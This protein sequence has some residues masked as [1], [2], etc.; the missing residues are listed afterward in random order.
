M[1]ELHINDRY[2]YFSPVAP[3]IGGL[4]NLRSLVLSIECIEEIPESIGKLS[5]LRKLEISY[6]FFLE[7]L[8]DSIGNL[9]A[10]QEILIDNCQALQ[11]LPD[12][13]GDLLALRDISIVKCPALS[14]LP[15]S[16]ISLL[17]RKLKEE[18]GAMERVEF[19]KSPGLA[20]SL[21][22]DLQCKYRQE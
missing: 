17:I 2:G 11:S 9:T 13:T 5:Q 22:V 3:S 18:D 19:S 16:L 14:T 6:S 8:P 1:P 21:P 12:S 10:L 15:D 4:Q 20:M 7:V